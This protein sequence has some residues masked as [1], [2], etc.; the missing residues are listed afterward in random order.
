MSCGTGTCRTSGT[1]HTLTSPPTETGIGPEAI[2]FNGVPLKPTSSSY[3]HQYLLRP[4]TIE[5]VFYM[6]R[7]THDQKWRDMAWDMMRSIQRYCATPNGYA[8]LTDV[9]K[10]KGAPSKEDAEKLADPEKLD[11][12]DAGLQHVDLQESFFIA[13]T[14]KYFMLIFA[15]DELLPLDQWVFNTE[16]HP[17]PVHSQMGKKRKKKV[18]KEE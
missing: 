11:F 6:W 16:A 2:E 4:E 8:G 12:V 14:L 15:D 1:T 13:E 10:G 7:L 18:I 17:M 5:S 3:G 9:S